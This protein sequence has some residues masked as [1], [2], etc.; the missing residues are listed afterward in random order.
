MDNDKVKVLHNRPSPS[1]LGRKCAISRIYSIV[2]FLGTAG[3]FRIQLAPKLRAVRNVNCYLDNLLC[4]AA[5]SLLTKLRPKL[6]CQGILLPAQFMQWQ[7]RHDTD[8]RRS[9]F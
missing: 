5:Y 1:N 2:C 3:L 8:I 7:A 9:L 6:F 4:V